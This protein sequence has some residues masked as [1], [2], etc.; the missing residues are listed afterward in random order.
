[1]RKFLVD[2]NYKGFLNTFEDL[3]GMKQFR[4][5]N[6]RLMA[7]GYGFAGRRRLENGGMVRTMKVM[8]AGLPAVI[9]L[10]KIIRIILNRAMKWCWAVI[11]WKFVQVLPMENQVEIHPLGIG[12]KA[13]P[14]RLV[15]NAGAGAALNASLMDMG[16]RFRLLVNTVD[17]VKPQHDLPKLPVAKGIM[18]TSKYERC[19]SCMDLCRWC[20][21]YRL[22]PKPYCRKHG[23]FCRYGRVEFV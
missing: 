11:C 14:V 16:N 9:H 20:T 6:Q 3:H 17:A 22:Q 2:G 21:S 10:W 23:R 1:M 19:I 4:I 7:D 18:A 5:P 8:G 15:F 12:G 13:D